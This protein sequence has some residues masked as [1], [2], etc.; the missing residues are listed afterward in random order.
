RAA[1]VA[2]NCGALPEN[3]LESELFGHVKGAF[4]GADRPKQ[5]LFE[6]A[7]GGTVF[8]D[9]VAELPLA[10][11]P[12]LLRALELSEI[13]PVGAVE[14]RK[15]DIR[16][17]AATNRE[18][19]EAVA[20]GRFRD[21]LYWR[22]NVLQIHVP[23]LRERRADIPA[24]AEHFLQ[25]AIE[26]SGVDRSGPTSIAPEAMAM[27]QSYPWPGNVRELRNVL[28]RA[29]TLGA[30]PAVRPEDLSVRIRDSGQVASLV[31]AAARRQLNL[32]EVE[33]LYILEVLRQTGGNRSR[34]AEVLGLD[35][36]TLYRRLEEYRSEQPPLD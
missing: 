12:K 18:L 27:I 5:G 1:F 36:K 15:V 21:D 4:T 34:A 31:D 22:L 28:Q 32:R 20:Q 16:V 9:E 14:D 30:G 13:R 6:V 2:V 26:S 29:A 3:L 19:E 25:R 17:I 10:L 24:L 7:H 35:R 33:R 11:Q 8:L 23:P